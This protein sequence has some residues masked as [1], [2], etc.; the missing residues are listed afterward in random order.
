MSEKKTLMLYQDYR[1]MFEVLDPA[2]AKDLLM[3]LFKYNVGEDV[4]LEGAPMAVFALI[5]NQMDRDQKKYEERAKTSRENG[6]RG[7]RPAKEPEEEKNNQNNPA[8]YSKTQET[9]QVISKPRKPD[10]DTDTDTDT[11]IDIKDKNIVQIASDCEPSLDLASTCE[12]DPA[13]DKDTSAKRDEQRHKDKEAE[14]LFEFL[15]QQ[16]PVKRG[17]GNVSKTQKLSLA[18]IGREELTRALER[19]K[20]DV[21]NASFDLSFKNGSTFFNSGYI[22][23]LDANYEARPMPLKRGKVPNNI[24]ASHS[25][26]EHESRAAVLATMEE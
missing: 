22:D 18:R 24:L 14:K 21:A 25:I 16:Y 12:T 23:Y 7:G 11:D 4:S 15:W 3:A 9:Q 8:G 6:K 17:K 20:S 26:K 19:Y 13:K 2:D 1:D 10:T 5:K